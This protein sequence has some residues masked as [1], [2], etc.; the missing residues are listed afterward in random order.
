M[1][2]FE[3]TGYFP[4]ERDGKYVPVFGTLTSY[5]VTRPW[6]NY[7]TTDYFFTPDDGGEEV[8]V[9]NHEK[10]L[11]DEPSLLDRRCLMMSAIVYCG[12]DVTRGYCPRQLNN[13]I[14]EYE[15]SLS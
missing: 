8:K 7:T 6:N 10:W 3:G 14:A 1:K 11:V 15:K 13:F 12:G 5:T 4:L 9:T 2:S